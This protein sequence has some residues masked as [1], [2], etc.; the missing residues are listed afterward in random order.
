MGGDKCY[1]AERERCLTANLGENVLPCWAE[2]DILY[3]SIYL[4]KSLYI[5]N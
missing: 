2:K 4:Q 5:Y 1:A 3:A